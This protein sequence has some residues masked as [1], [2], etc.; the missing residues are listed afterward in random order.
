MIKVLVSIVAI[1]C[2]IVMLIL[3]MA[4]T[5]DFTDPVTKEKHVDKEGKIMGYIGFAICFIILYGLYKY[6]FKS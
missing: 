3:S 5:K 1:T 6:I 4:L 2:A